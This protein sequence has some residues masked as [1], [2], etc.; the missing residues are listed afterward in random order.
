MDQGEG[1]TTFEIITALAFLHFSHCRVDAAV[2]EV[3]LGGRLDATNVVQ[4][5]VSV[6][7]SL[8]YAHA[9]LMGETLGEIAREKGG[10]I[11]A[12]VP[13]VSASPAAAARRGS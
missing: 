1:L 10:I 13:L 11:K 2:I 8:G 6:I 4:P 5:L 7:T 9:Y 3:G 12:G